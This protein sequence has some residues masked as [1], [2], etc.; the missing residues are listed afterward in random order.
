M[1][2]DEI[3]QKMACSCRIL[4]MEGITEKGRGHICFLHPDGDKILIPGHLHDYGKAIAD[5]QADDIVTIDFGGRVL[6]GKYSEPMGEF[7]AYTSIFRH[8]KDVKSIA[9]FHPPYANIVAAAGKSIVPVTRDG[10]LFYEGVPVY[11]GFPLYCGTTKMGDEIAA[12]LGNKRAV[13]HRAHG[14]FV[15]GH[16][17][18]ETLVTA[19]FLEKAARDQV[20]TSVL[21]A[22]TPIPTERMTER[23]KNPDH[24]VIDD[25]FGFYCGKLARMERQA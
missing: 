8:R 5:V 2:L 18:E 1:N 12:A 7:Y 19:I 21:A 23:E 11:E 17:V 22:P 24:H 20:Y 10:C 13:L 3:K 4:E 15:V 16:S 25:F 6:E 9:H 14:A